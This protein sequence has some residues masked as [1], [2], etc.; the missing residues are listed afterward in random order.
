V[1]KKPR[2]TVGRARVARKPVEATASDRLKLLV[3]GLRNSARPRPARKPTPLPRYEEH[4]VAFIDLL[5]FRQLVESMTVRQAKE[6]VAR[7]E[8]Q[9]EH[10][11]EPYR[12]PDGAKDETLAIQVNYFSDCMCLALPLRSAS[13]KE[14]IDKIFWFVLHVL[15]V[16]GEFVFKKRLLRGGIVVDRHYASGRLIFSRAQVKAYDVEHTQ[17][18]DPHVVIDESVFRSIK[19]AISKF[20]GRY[21]FGKIGF[22]SDVHDLEGL[23]ATREDG[24]S[25][26]NYLGFWSELDDPDHTKTFFE[27]H[28]EMIVEGARGGAATAA[29]VNKL[30]ALA[31]YHNRYAAL[32]FGE[33]VDDLLIAEDAF[34]TIVFRTPTDE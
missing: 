21:E 15:H 24:K 26:V 1:K 9:L 23:L 6:E 12:G 13:L 22:D 3:E 14:Y 5:G 34:G 16:Q 20:K 4:I 28:K 29:V 8:Q 25:F 19:R 10:V 17:A 2:P 11:V 30:R 7:L 31:R 33:G 32:L 27:R 18:F